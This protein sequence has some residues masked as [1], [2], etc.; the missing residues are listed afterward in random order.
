[1]PAPPPGC[2]P[3]EGLLSACCGGEA[4]CWE[5]ALAPCRRPQ[6]AACWPQGPSPLPC[7]LGQ[8]SCPDGRGEAQGAV[9]VSPRPP[10]LPSPY[11]LQEVQVGIINSAIC[12]YLYA[13]P[14]FRYDIWGDMI[15]AGTIQGGKDA[16]FVSVPSQ[17]NQ[18][19]PGPGR[20]PPQPQA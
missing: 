20:P 14:V 12:N 19:P 16:C 2:W 8:S 10:E 18:G 1:M 15:C 9:F 4:A 11:I 3:P 6:W 5:G 7:S 13:Q 17:P